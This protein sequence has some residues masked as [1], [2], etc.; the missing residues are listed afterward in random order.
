[1]ERELIKQRYL[2]AGLAR[3]AGADPSKLS[4]LNV[5]QFH[6]IEIDEFPARIAEVALWMTDHIANTRLGQ[7]F[8][9]PFAR[10]P[11]VAAP[12]IRHGD[13]LEFDWNDLLPADRCSYIL[14]NPP[15]AGQ[16]FQS[17][18][19]RE[20]M[21]RMLGRHGQKAGSLD[22]VAAWFIKAGDYA[23][24]CHPR[25]AFVAT[26]SIMQGEQVAQ[27]WPILFHRLRMEIAFGHRTFVWP[28]H[29]GV[30]CVIV[31][32]VCA[33][34]EPAEKRLF[35]YIDG[36]GEPIETRP[37][38]LTAYL[39]DAKTADRHLLVREHRTPL[40][41]LAPGMRMGSK[42]VDGGHYIFD[43]NERAAFLL[44]QPEA[45]SLLVPLIGSKEYIQGGKR[46]ILD[47]QDIEPRVLRN[48]KNVLERIA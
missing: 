41:P 43:G 18:F 2:R 24:G 40:N 46:W 31:G 11:L 47:L 22:Y 21:R 17:A 37:D 5:D 34:D 9:Q 25:I 14:G 8:G 45:E 32:L 39:F 28:G 4:R 42:I 35:S 10:I 48:L 30:H 26:N 20:Q 7:D 38:A 33:G 19:Q 15:F 29:A 13:A 1:L 16:S 6:G 36:K 3:G 44:L 23:Q 27:L 12:S